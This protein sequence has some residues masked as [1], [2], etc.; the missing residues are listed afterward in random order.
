MRIGIDIDDVVCDT[1]G[2]L[3][4][5]LSKY[6]KVDI[7][8]LINN[9]RAIGYYESTIANYKDFARSYYEQLIRDAPLKPRV[10]FYLN[11]LKEAGHDLIFITARSSF[12]F[13]DPY[14]LTVDYFHKH[15]IPYDKIIVE[16]FNK[17]EVC[18]REGVRVMIDDYGA[19]LALMESVGVIPIIMTMPYN[20]DE[21]YKYRASNWQE[22]YEIIQEL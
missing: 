10:V 18:L 7:N 20:K 1:Y 17:P 14:R 15:R 9:P 22:I 16:A 12:E 3:V 8:K 5:K 13:T 6:Y 19:N 11:K 2:I 21:H 4:R